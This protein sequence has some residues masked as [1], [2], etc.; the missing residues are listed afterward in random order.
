MFEES[1]ASSTESERRMAEKLVFQSRKK[2][3]KGKQSVKESKTG[4]MRTDRNV[5]KTLNT[6]LKNSIKK[7]QNL[8]PSQIK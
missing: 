8:T 4:P 7:I 2:N 5:Q 3:P 6:L 1:N